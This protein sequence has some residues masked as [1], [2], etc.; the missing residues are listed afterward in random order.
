MRK[1]YNKSTRASDMYVRMCSGQYVYVY[2]TGITA[3]IGHGVRSA[4][5]DKMT[6]KV[7]SS[8]SMAI[9]V[10][11]SAPVAWTMA[12]SHNNHRFCSEQN[13]QNEEKRTA[14]AHF[15]GLQE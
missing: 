12:D 14:A 9:C 1:I 3:I 2:A 4:Q 5:K 15:E 7:I 13:E 6:I 10:C 8:F 11:V